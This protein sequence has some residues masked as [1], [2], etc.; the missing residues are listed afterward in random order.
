MKFSKVNKN[1]SGFLLAVT[2]HALI[3]KVGRTQYEVTRP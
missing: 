2:G 1:H 3:V